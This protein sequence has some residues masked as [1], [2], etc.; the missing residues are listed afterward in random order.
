MKLIDFLR[1]ISKWRKTLYF[2]VIFLTIVSVVLAF[3]LPKSYIAT[4][5]FIPVTSTML[6]STYRELYYYIGIRPTPSRFGEVINIGDIF[7]KF[8]TE[9]KVM[10]SVVEKTKLME[11]KKIKEIKKAFEWLK[12]KTNIKATP[13]GVVEISVSSEKDTLSVDIAN[14]YIDALIEIT[15]GLYYSY[16]KWKLKFLEDAMLEAKNRVIKLADSLA[17]LKKKYNVFNIDREYNFS[18]QVYSD[19]K[20]QE[21]EKEIEIKTL[22]SYTSPDNPQLKKLKQELSNIR[23]KLKDLETHQKPLGFGGIYGSSI[24]ILPDIY[25]LLLRTETEYRA[26]EGSFAYISQ[27]YE[28]AKIEANTKINLVNVLSTA[29]PELV[30][31]FPKKSRI[32]LLGVFLSLIFSIFLCFYFELLE[33]IETKEEFSQIKEILHKFKRDFSLRKK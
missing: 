11:K 30:E 29:R 1:V 31:K 12:D 25:S 8:L 20:K 26:M 6:P 15:E 2:N 27:E 10:E 9:K 17:S 4:S 23:K 3:L 16:T 22:E 33:N 28:K 18:Y 21:I 19:L 5:S 14:A 13:E 32:I 7:A 24:K